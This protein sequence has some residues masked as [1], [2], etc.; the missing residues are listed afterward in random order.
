MDDLIPVRRSVL[1][2][3]INR[4]E[5]VYLVPIVRDHYWQRWNDLHDK[6]IDGLCCGHCGGEGTTLSRDTIN[7]PDGFRHKADCPVLAV[8]RLVEP[9]AFEEQP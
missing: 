3:L 4:D 1:E 5:A 7:M 6:A 2:K 8:Q 9:E